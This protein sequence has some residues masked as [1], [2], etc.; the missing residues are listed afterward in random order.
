MAIVAARYLAAKADILRPNTYRAA[1]LHFAVHRK[2]LADRPLDSIKR[3]DVAARLQ[4]IVQTHGR[5]AAARARGNLS[6]LFGWAM[7]EGLCE[8]NPVLVTNDPAEGIEARDRVLTDR[9]L[10]A[11]WDSRDDDF[12]RIVKLLI[13]T[14]CRREADRRA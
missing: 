12:G 5:T 9:E 8:A 7:R 1:K 3:A 4:E 6:A 13:L 11:V 2:P 10:A 14:G